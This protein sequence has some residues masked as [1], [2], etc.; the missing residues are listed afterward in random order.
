MLFFLLA[1][2]SFPQKVR[3]AEKQAATVQAQA[4]LVH[5]LVDAADEAG[6]PQALAPLRSHANEMHDAM[7]RLSAIVAQ[8]EAEDPEVSPPSP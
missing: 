6:R 7:Q 1:G 2:L 3:S 8:L 5:G 4:A